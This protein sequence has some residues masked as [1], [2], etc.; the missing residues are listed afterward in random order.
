MINKCHLKEIN[1]KQIFVKVHN[2]LFSIKKS[3]S[4]GGRK[5][6]NYIDI[7]PLVNLKNENNISL[8]KEPDLWSA[9]DFIKNFE[10]MCPIKFNKKHVIKSDQNLTSFLQYDKILNKIKAV[11]ISKNF[12]EKFFEF[13]N[14]ENE[15]E[16]EN[17]FSFCEENLINRI[18]VDLEKIRN[19]NRDKTAH[20]K[21][22][23]KF[24]S[25]DNL[26]FN[27][28][29]INTSLKKVQ[30]NINL[31]NIKNYIFLGID[32]SRKIIKN[33][34]FLSHLKDTVM[35]N[36]IFK[37]GY[38]NFSNKN[39]P[40]IDNSS[41]R[42]D[43]ISNKQNF[44]IGQD[45]N[46][47][48]LCMISQFEFSLIPIKIF[49]LNIEVED[50][51]NEKKIS[52]DFEINSID[53]LVESEILRITLEEMRVL[54]NEFKDKLKEEE[55]EPSENSGATQ[56]EQFM[57]FLSSTQIYDKF[58]YD[59]KIIDIENYLNGNELI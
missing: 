36:P 24:K 32:P 22:S 18:N 31:Y 10:K 41:V 7:K 13:L 14:S 49:K 54:E 1:Y 6:K 25:D 27:K 37:G 17:L 21:Y 15:N 50:A 57:N 40:S 4:K 56:N 43:I 29:I 45:L 9:E 8:D 11:A 20:L 30:F 51:L 26:Q 42:T 16:I 46:K 5:E 47:I 55:N 34:K 28:N 38:E 19:F 33:Y 59:L 44:M 35:S 3:N 39:S 23:L 48:P 12:L 2:K 53:F 58:K 52:H